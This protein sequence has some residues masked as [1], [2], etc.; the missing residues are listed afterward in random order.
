M[1]KLLIA[2][3]L[4]TTLISCGSSPKESKATAEAQTKAENLTSYTID[5]LLT[6]AEGLV[7][8]KVVLTA[9]VSHTCKHSGR[10]AFFVGDDPNTT[11]RV[12]SGGSIGG[13][14]R[15]LIGSELAVTGT[16]RERRLTKEYLNQYE[17]E[18]KEKMAGDDGSVE[19]CGSELKNIEGMR[20]WMQERG[21]DYYATYF[22]D[23]ESFEVVE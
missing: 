7:G 15:E 12:E 9:T 23:G 22:M 10:R 6:A 21:K 16:L 11:F 18:L 19:S 14:N 1:K 17:E 2:A 8:K 4:L 13:F 3:V 20:S 5:E